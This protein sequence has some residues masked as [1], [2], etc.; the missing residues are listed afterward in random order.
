MTSET[1]RVG[2]VGCGIV[3]GAMLE[4]FET[5]KIDVACYDKFKQ[6]ISDFDVLLNTDVLF[7]CLPTQYDEELK[8]YDYT[9]IHD[10]MGT[11]CD[12][13][14]GGLVVFRSTVTPGTTMKLRAQYALDICY[15]PE[16][17]SAK[18][19]YED[20]VVQKHII[21][22][23]EDGRA[24]LERTDGTSVQYK[25][26][27]AF[28]RTHWPASRIS[29]SSTTEAEMAKLF[30]NSFYSV[31]IG[32]FNEFYDVCQKS[33]V[34][35][36]TVKELMLRNDWINPMHTSVPGHDGHFGFGGLC[37]IKDTNSLSDYMLSEGIGNEILSSTIVENQQ[38]RNLND[39]NINCVASS[40]SSSKTNTET[41]LVY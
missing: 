25:Q 32:M 13:K 26:L 16:F 18:T 33:D 12:H 40:S 21:I 41:Q 38:R 17:L 31:K 1:Y 34:E 10:V 30:C 6:E 15:Y 4:F 5:A 14:Y 23:L 20:F 24:A 37:F 2:V 35:F 11:L 3:G 27:L 36:D 8:A 19:A 29:I 39:E 7:L 9:A 28:F 22:G